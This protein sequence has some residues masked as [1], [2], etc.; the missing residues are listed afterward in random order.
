[1]KNIF[2]IFLIIF[3]IVVG[4]FYFHNPKSQLIKQQIDL[5]SLTLS[6]FINSEFLQGMGAVNI[7][8]T[9]CS[10][11]YQFDK[12]KYLI[13]V[14]ESHKCSPGNSDWF[15]ESYT[16]NTFNKSIFKIQ[17]YP[18]LGC[19]NYSYALKILYSDCYFG[20]SSTKNSMSISIGENGLTGT[21]GGSDKDCF[22]QLMGNLSQKF[23]NCSTQ[24]V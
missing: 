13:Q 19:D 15:S 24:I 11:H 23:T 21:P 4:V 12:D 3:V 7:S 1:M 8:G 9:G 20:I 16:I 18:F 10:S 14:Y 22:Y 5:S 6:T 2:I 17:E